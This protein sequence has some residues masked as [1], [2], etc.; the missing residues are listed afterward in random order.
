MTESLTLEGD[1]L[2]RV[3]SLLRANAL[4]R[5]PHTSQ[6]LVIAVKPLSTDTRDIAAALI[7]ERLLN[8]GP[9]RE[10]ETRRDEAQAR[11]CPCVWGGRGYIVHFVRDCA[12]GAEHT[13]WPFA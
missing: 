7:V 2:E 13:G 9:P 10:P 5:A 8:P 11:G 4:A 1:T 6:D 3:S 12:V